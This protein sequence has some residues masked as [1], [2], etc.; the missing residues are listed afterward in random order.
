MIKSARDAFEAYHSGDHDACGRL[1]GQISGVKGSH[2]V[3]HNTHLNDYYKSGCA[4]PQS[5]LA[6]LSQVHEKAREH[7][8]KDKGRRK[9]DD[10]DEEAGQDEDLSVLRYNQALLCVQL[11]HYAQAALILE[12]LFDNIE[13]IDDFLAIKIC[14]L[15]LEFYLLQRE[16][17]QA[18]CVLAYLE[19][20]NA[21]LSVLRSERPKAVER[22]GD[23]ADVADADGKLT[24][25][26]EA[27]GD[28][29]LD[30][31]AEAVG[32]PMERRAA[33]SACASEQ[34]PDT[35]GPLP[36]LML[37]AFLPRHGRAPDAIVRSE[38]RFFCLVYRARISAALKNIKAAKRDVKAAVDVLEELRHAPLLTPHPH[39]TGKDGKDRASEALKRGLQCQ[40]NAIVLALKANLE[41]SRQNVRKAMKLLTLCKFNF[42][43]GRPQGA[44]DEELKKLRDKGK[45]GDDDGD[46]Q[47]LVDFHPAQDDACAAL[48]LNNLGCVHFLMRK[49]NL[50][51]LY[52][53][54]ALQVPKPGNALGG[55]AGLTLPGVLAT[56]HWLD[57]RAEIAY[58]AGLQ[59]LMTGR[60]RAA[61]GCLEQC[62]QVFRTWPRLWLRLAECCIEMQAEPQKESGRL[63]AGVRGVGARRRWSLR[64]SPREPFVGQKPPE[65][66]ED[67]GAQSNSVDSPFAPGGVSLL[68]YAAM[69][70]RNVLV[71]VAPLLVER[72]VPDAAAHDEASAR[73]SMNGAPA[74]SGT[75]DASAPSAT[76]ATNDKASASARVVSGPGVAPRHQARDLVRCEASLLEDVALVKLAYVSL[77]QHDGASALKHSRKLLEKNHLLRSE[78]THAR[79]EADDSRRQWTLQAQNLQGTSSAVR[80]P[81]SIGCVMLAVLYLAEA[82]LL[83]GKLTEAQ[84]LLGSFV[85][86]NAL[87][88]GLEFQRTAMSELE[89]SAS[90]QVNA[91]RS[92][93]EISAG[94]N[95]NDERWQA[96]YGKDARP[97]ASVSLDCPV[98]GLTSPAHLLCS[99]ALHAP[100]ERDVEDTEKARS[101]GSSHGQ[102]GDGDKEKVG[103]QALLVVYP[104]SEF[105]RLGEAQSILLSSMANLHAQDGNLEEAERCCRRALQL[106]P[107]AGGALRTLVYVLLKEGR[108]EHALLCLKQSRMEG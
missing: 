16:P 11:R 108:H 55:K 59:L 98:G 65:D 38:Y 90:V 103:G 1:L 37:G 32:A 2:D 86:S 84:T 27:E 83:L 107:K 31:L 81:S 15:L 30:T 76:A 78:E 14:F 20:P 66:K 97:P 92:I 4:D 56:R 5:L 79:D 36:S 22:V 7:N 54:K 100:K 99:S 13:P 52:F 74:A 40:H 64:T 70:L 42:A 58:N 69:C 3:A 46:D 68:T 95:V 24:T 45:A 67:K 53:Q 34:S 17:E 62:A 75:S 8:K 91:G 57:Q 80:Y 29:A 94:D 6:Q 18:L 48:F 19:K 35:E 41:Y 23:D 87:V 33:A 85:S 47:I 101:T 105:P 73:G 82:L 71:H 106:Q 102:G 63:V 10:G 44:G 50:A 88:N 9:R 21:F 96:F 61:F 93:G 72:G 89:R 12:D 39:T 49:P 77:C 60:P 28:E 43:E 25:C 104:P 26:T 51:T